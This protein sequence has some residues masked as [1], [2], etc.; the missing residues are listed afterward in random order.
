MFVKGDLEGF[1]VFGDF[2][3]GFLR[4]CCSACYDELRVPFSCKSRGGYPSC[5]GLRMA[6]GAASLVDHVL[7][8]VGY[9]Q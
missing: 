3:L 8:A 6:E 9:R 5:M 1:A 7:L 4:T 2:E